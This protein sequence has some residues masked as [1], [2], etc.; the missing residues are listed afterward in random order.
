MHPANL[1]NEASKKCFFRRKVHQNERLL[2]LRE[3]KQT[4][5]KSFI[6]VCDAI[7]IYNQIIINK[8]EVPFKFQI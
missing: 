2:E 8:Y 3:I 7:V 4:M 1:K 5:F 6:Q